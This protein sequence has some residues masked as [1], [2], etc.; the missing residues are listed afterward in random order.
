MR[1]IERHRGREGVMG[2]ANSDVT[3]EKVSS[4]VKQRRRAKRSP[5]GK[6]TVDQ[7]EGTKR[8]EGLKKIRIAVPPMILEGKVSIDEL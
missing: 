3:D 7:R 5:R 2:R 8:G 6:N 1:G 4:V